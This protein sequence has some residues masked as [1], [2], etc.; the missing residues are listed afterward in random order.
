MHFTFFARTKREIQVLS[1]TIVLWFAPGYTKMEVVAIL[2]QIQHYK[3]NIDF[4]FVFLGS[5]R[6]IY[7]I[8]RVTKENEKITKKKKLQK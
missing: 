6:Q 5:K 3:Y 4:V 1:F 2:Q 8:E 7:L